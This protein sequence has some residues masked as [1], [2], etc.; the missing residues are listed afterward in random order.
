MGIRI[1]EPPRRVP[2]ASMPVGFLVS[3]SFGFCRGPAGWRIYYKHLVLWLF[4]RRVQLYVAVLDGA[5]VLSDGS[6]ELID[7]LVD[8]SRYVPDFVVVVS[9]GNDLLTRIT[10][11]LHL[12]ADV[13]NSA[14]VSL[15]LGR[16]RRRFPGA[17]WGLFYGGSSALFGYER[18][19][20]GVLYDDA[21]GEVLAQVR[22]V[23]DFVD[24]L[25]RLTPL[26]TIDRI[27]HL[28]YSDADRV[29][30]YMSAVIVDGLGLRLPYR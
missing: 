25:D 29:L 10:Y 1:L 7:S 22:D 28:D 8:R 16:L 18:D 19:R 27:G 5:R 12:R 26:S 30:D 3:D 13:G 4:A 9:M 6:L 11:P 21:V 17:S 23:Y 14:N 15:A 24:K 20:G 2:A